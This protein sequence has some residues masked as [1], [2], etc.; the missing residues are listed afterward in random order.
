MADRISVWLI[1]KAHSAQELVFA[2][3][4]KGRYLQKGITFY[5][6]LFC[7]IADPFSDLS[8]PDPELLS[9]GSAQLAH[10]GPNCKI[11]SEKLQG[12]FLFLDW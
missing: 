6:N 1:I 4:L 12:F 2:G 3:Y 7:A 5:Y 10:Y 11:L 9:W 8:K